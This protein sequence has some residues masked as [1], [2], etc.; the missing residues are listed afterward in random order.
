MGMAFLCT[1]TKDFGICDLLGTSRG[2]RELPEG[3]EVLLRVPGEALRGHLGIGTFCWLHSRE[4]EIDRWSSKLS[5]TRLAFNLLPRPAA[6]SPV[7][8]QLCFSSP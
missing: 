4:P 1:G 2:C 7:R 6:L 5:P 3:S 8:T